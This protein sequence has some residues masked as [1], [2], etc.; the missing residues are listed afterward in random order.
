[1]REEAEK[2]LCSLL[3]GDILLLLLFVELSPMFVSDGVITTSSTLRGRVGVIL[4]ND[5][6]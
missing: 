3:S 2:R 4:Y 1:M 6:S 5:W